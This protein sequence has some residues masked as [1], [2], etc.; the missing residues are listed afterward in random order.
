MG[1]EPFF[2]LAEFVSLSFCLSPCLLWGEIISS[3]EGKRSD[4]SMAP[5]EIGRFS[6]RK[7]SWCEAGRGS[8]G[9]GAPSS[10]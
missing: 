6:E 10:L 3:L 1:R 5:G 7:A 2:S 4:L 8:P 9:L